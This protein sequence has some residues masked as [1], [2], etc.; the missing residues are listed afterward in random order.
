MLHNLIWLSLVLAKH[1]FAVV[2]GGVV[3]WVAALMRLLSAVLVIH[4]VSA[5]EVRCWSYRY[6]VRTWGGYIWEVASF[7]LC[8]SSLLIAAPVWILFVTLWFCALFVYCYICLLTFFWF[9]FLFS[10]SIVAYLFLIVC[11]FLYLRLI[12]FRLAC[13][14][15]Y[16]P[17]ANQMARVWHAFAT[18]TVVMC[19]WSCIPWVSGGRYILTCAWYG[20]FLSAWY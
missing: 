13:I 9:L 16:L 3:V 1:A 19:S 6:D 20:F 4:H 5:L 15:Q 8:C 11:L 18:V 14:V 12:C 7:A 10:V 2:R 17:A